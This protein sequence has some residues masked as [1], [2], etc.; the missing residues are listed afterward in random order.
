MSALLM[1]R[2][3]GGAIVKIRGIGIVLRT[4]FGTVIGHFRSAVGTEQKFSQRIGFAKRIVASRC[5]SQ[6]LCKLPPFLICNRFK[7]VL[8]DQPVVTVSLRII[9]KI[10]SSIAY[11][12]EHLDRDRFVLPHFGYRIARDPRLFGKL[13]L[14]HPFI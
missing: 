13:E 4:A 9:R 14:G 7:G 3:V 1:C 12:S 5:L 6:F 2:R 8:K 10:L 11:L